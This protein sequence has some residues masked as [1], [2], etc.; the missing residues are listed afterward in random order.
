MRFAATILLLLAPAAFPAGPADAARGAKILSERQC[1]QCHDFARHTGRSL[2]GPLAKLRKSQLKPAQLV[3]AMWSHLPTMTAAAGSHAPSFQPWSE[4]DAADLLAWFAA[5]G[6]FDPAGDSK[7]GEALFTSQGCVSCHPLSAVANGKPANGDTIPVDGWK[8]LHNPIALLHSVWR[9]APSMKA[10]LDG[11]TMRWPALTVPEFADLLAFVYSR[12]PANG[13]GVNLTLGDAEKGKAIFSMKGCSSCHAKMPASREAGLLHSF[14][15][16]TAIFWNHA[17][18]MTSL[19]ASLNREEIADVV[20]YLWVSRY[21]ED[22]GSVVRGRSVFQRK[23]CEACHNE[24]RP[25]AKNSAVAMLAA[26]WK[27]APAAVEQARG[28]GISW[29]KFESGE[30][31]DLIAYLSSLIR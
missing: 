8:S 13:A 25:V 3:G 29:P 24:A 21:F 5:A 19:P 6:Y 15:E 22:S 7:R 20:A 4:Q 30:M 17:P 23:H 11:K 1:L 9:H 18:M 14:T 2:V 16:L 12:V 27:H 28:K 26:A 10:A 31:G